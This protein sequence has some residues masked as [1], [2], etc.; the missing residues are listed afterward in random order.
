M[1]QVEVLSKCLSNIAP[2]LP[3]DYIEKIS[4]INPE[5][6]VD[7][8]RN[9]FRGRLKD[10]DKLIKILTTARELGQDNFN[11]YRKASRTISRRLKQ[12]YEQFI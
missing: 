8:V 3:K 12:M 7:T 9:A 1:T 11:K 5:C 6:S 4:E 2:F 10:V